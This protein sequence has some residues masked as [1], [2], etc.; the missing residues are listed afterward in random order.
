LL[1]ASREEVFDMWLSP[2]SLRRWMRPG[3]TEVAY[4]AVN[5]VV[6]G[7]F[8]I[9]MRD[10]DGHI[11]THAG[12]YLE[13]QRPDKLSFT[14]NSTVLGA[15]SSQVTVEFYEQEGMCLMVLSH[16]LPPDD[17]LI[18]D[19]RKG[20]TTILNLLAEQQKGAVR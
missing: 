2:E 16:E 5:P 17:A 14:W 3:D 20:W 13:I 9:D 6:G 11:F 19:H 1:P 8:R 7:T 15:H 10:Q 18:E 4:A 12:Q